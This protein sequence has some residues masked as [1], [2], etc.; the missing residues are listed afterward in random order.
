[1]T[2][3]LVRLAWATLPIT[4]G[5]AAGDALADWSTPPRTLAEV[6]LWAAWA[7]SLVALLAP[8]PVGLTT[9]RV[10]GPT[11]VVL[12]LVVVVTGS[13]DSVRAAVALVATSVAGAL[14]IA[15][16][17]ISFAC[18]NGVA[19]GDE[20]RHPLRTPPALWL[21]PLPAAPL[22]VAAGVATGPLLL[23]D[24]RVVAGVVV[25]LAGVP[26]AALAARSLHSLSTRWAVLVP[27]GLVVVDAM[28]L[29]DPVLFM[30]ERIESLRP[31]TRRER[32][33]ATTVDLR[34][35]A[36]GGSVAMS[37]DRPTEVV[38]VR[39]GRG[40]AGVEQLT[41]LCF[42]TVYSAEFLASAAARRIRVNV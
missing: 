29:A 7:V 6:L 31:V 23:A 12:A 33:P 22:L 20:R 18:A 11:F 14:A 32:P 10:V 3:W 26:V 39:R 41:A 28:T 5:A 36:R 35:G 15:L 17:A 25:L 27:A 30:R 19:Y 37:L 1:M 13:A 34:L 24:G 8:H 4:V 2:L 16:P 42:A 9:V 40:R 38:R 21:G